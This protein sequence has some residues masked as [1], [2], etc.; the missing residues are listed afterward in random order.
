MP[1]VDF[2]FVFCDRDIA[3]QKSGFH[4][5]KVISPE[6]MMAN[7]CGAPIF[8]ITRKFSSEIRQFLLSN[9]VPGDNII[10]M[11]NFFYERLTG[12]YFDMPFLDYGDHEVFVEAGSHNLWTTVLLSKYCPHLDRVFAFEPSPYSFKASEE[13]KEKYDLSYVNLYPY[14]TWSKKCTLKFDDTMGDGARVKEDGGIQVQAVPIDDI[15]GDAKVTFIK[16]DVEGAELESLKGARN[17][18]MNNKP[19]LAICIYHKPED[20][21]TLPLYIKSMEPSYKLYIR[22]L[23]NVPDETVLFAV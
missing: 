14:A 21:L 15:V 9:G 8:V 17:T 12:Y 5:H 7:Y 23:A 16:M 2:P 13:T 6:E 1:K 10:N 11:H 20:M 4:G 22:H 3:K 19:K 18:I